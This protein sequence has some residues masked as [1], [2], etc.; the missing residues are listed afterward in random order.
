MGHSDFSIPKPNETAITFS[1]VSSQHQHRQQT[2]VFQIE[3]PYASVL[4]STSSDP[5]LEEVSTR[6]KP[7][8]L[9]KT[10]NGFFLFMIDARKQLQLPKGAALDSAGIC[11]LI[12]NQWWDLDAAERK[13]YLDR[14]AELRREPG[15]RNLKQTKKAKTPKV[16]RPGR[17]FARRSKILE[18]Y[19]QGFNGE[20]L[21]DKMRDFDA[22]R[23][24]K[25]SFQ[26]P[27][28]EAS[29]YHQK[30]GKILLSD[31]AITLS[32]S[33]DQPIANTNRNVP[34]ADSSCGHFTCTERTSSSYHSVTPSPDEQLP[35]SSSISNDEVRFAL[36]DRALSLCSLNVTE[37]MSTSVNEAPI[38]ERNPGYDV[39]FPTHSPSVPCLIPFSGY[40]S[41]NV[42]PASETVAYDV[43]QFSAH[44]PA[45]PCSEYRPTSANETIPI[46]ARIPGCGMPF[47]TR[48][49]T[50]SMPFLDSPAGNTTIVTLPS[51][52]STP[53]Y[54]APFTYADYVPYSHPG[55]FS[56][57][58]T[59]NL[60]PQNMSGILFPTRV[61][62]QG[63]SG[64]LSQNTLH[65]LSCVSSLF[66]YLQGDGSEGFGSTFNVPEIVSGNSGPQIP[67][68][69]GEDWAYLNALVSEENI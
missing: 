64:A 37:Y 11:M 51:D 49:P 50:V 22:N 5:K 18:L 58:S 36:S 43:A 56:T 12:R 10:P 46:Y 47:P 15:I 33:F 59:P 21:T 63:C 16:T 62:S 39:P 52:I 25:A 30:H 65:N 67:D 8:E 19:S 13:K 57:Y 40:L 20:D 28:T 41:S 45:V 6:A 7:A 31:D 24:I 17:D 23:T 55:I 60:D 44:S 61:T 68:F 4:E 38:Y 53:T 34:Q 29:F 69:A 2:Y 9:R 1:P 48:N 54:V 3:E 35:G 42:T 27:L 14:A 66:P 26:D 32:S